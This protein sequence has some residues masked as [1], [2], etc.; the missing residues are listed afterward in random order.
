MCCR[1]MRERGGEGGNAS[2]S[3]FSP[4]PSVDA[5]P[6]RVFWDSLIMQL[7]RE[8]GPVS[9]F[10]NEPVAALPCYSCVEKE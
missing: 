7:R 2:P 9:A 8:Y 5:H 3:G 6:S 10:H 4:P 1:P